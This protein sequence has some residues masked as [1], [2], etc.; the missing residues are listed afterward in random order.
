[1]N[2]I[3]KT[4]LYAC[5]L[6]ACACTKDIPYTGKG[7]NPMIVIN[8][9][10]RA[11]RPLDIFVSRSRFFLD[12]DE[13]TSKLSDASVTVTVNSVSMTPDFDEDKECFTDWRIVSPGDTVTVTASHPM[14]GTATST[15]IVPAP[16]R[17][18][19][20]KSAYKIFSQPSHSTV[21]LADSVWS[22]SVS[23]TPETEG[24]HYYRLTVFPEQFMFSQADNSLIAIF[25]CRFTESQST[26]MTLGLIDQ[27]SILEG[28]DEAHF[29]YGSSTYVF[30]DEMLNKD[31][32]LTF[33][34]AIDRP[35]G[36]TI[37]GDIS[38]DGSEIEYNWETEVDHT[39][40]YR[41]M[42]ILETISEDTY[43]YVESA[44]QY[45]ETGWSIFTEPVLVLSNIN[46]GLGVLGSSASTESM[47]ITRI[48]F[49]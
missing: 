2:R 16:S 1:M 31:D 47:P 42:F 22:L 36:E 5:V 8:C 43:R 40:E 14:F 4:I 34:V 13:G 29:Y 9:M 48:T 23:I 45:Q 7:S 25:P 46:G 24:L 21:A 15:S 19:L 26:R 12:S 3:I 11:G 37:L 30:T 33:E 10:A 20:E 27:E 17:I 39:I 49:E 6:T 38:A 18:A 44:H 35:L 32:L 28:D 41:C